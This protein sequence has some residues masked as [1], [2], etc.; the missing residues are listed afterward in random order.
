[1][2]PGQ[3]VTLQPAFAQVLAEHLHDTTVRRE[4]LV[5]RIDFGHPRFRRDIDDGAQAI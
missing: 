5:D 4:V 3:Q 1:M 2:A